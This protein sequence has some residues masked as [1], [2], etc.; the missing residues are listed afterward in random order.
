MRDD[1]GDA[2]G[3]AMTAAY[4]ARKESPGWCVVGPDFYL[5]HRERDICEA[6]AALLNGDAQTAQQI[7]ER[8]RG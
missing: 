1:M 7:V 3:R 6:I 8:W 2:Q 5:H 4:E